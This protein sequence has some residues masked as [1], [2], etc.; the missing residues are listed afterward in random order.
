MTKAN[1]ICY[2][3]LLPRDIRRAQRTT[4]TNGRLRA[5]SPIGKQ[6]VNGSTI[7][8]RFMSGTQVQRDMVERVAPEWTEHANLSFEFTDDPHAEVRVTFDEIDGAWSYV[9]TDNLN[10][11][12]HAATLN[13]G[14]LD[15]G[16][17]LHEFGHM[18]GLGHEHQNPDGGI[19]WNEQAVIDDL[20][21]PPNYWDLQTIRH[22]VLNKYTADQ[23]HGTEFDGA[24]VMLY[25]FPDEWT[26]NMGA[27]EDNDDLSDKDKAFIRSEQMYPTLP[28]PD[29]RAVVLPV[30]E[31]TT[32]D[33]SA[34]GE[35]DLYKFEISN[36]GQ[37]VVETTG[38]T[39]V[40][41]T[42]FG[43]NSL[44]QLV[45]EDDDGGTGTNARISAVLQSGTYYSRV[46]HYNP[47]RTGEYRIRVSAV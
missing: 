21:G 25:A 3:R 26:E 10:I 15:R 43:P 34:G 41:L 5:L 20:S 40:V 37:Y 8:V 31:A 33:I 47:I 4:T 27:T 17:I 22:N 24:S 35:E 42:L 23:I 13:L 44:T 30:C 29:E 11:P 1:N 28:A 36:E 39:D 16:V 6:W 46:R 9:G 12:L 7:R 19:I 38:S 18:I 14:W 32:A 45:A 2:D